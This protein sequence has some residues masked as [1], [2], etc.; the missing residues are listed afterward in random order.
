MVDA[1]KA[2]VRF[3]YNKRFLVIVRWTTRIG[4]CAATMIHNP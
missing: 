1:M 2:G 3:G 4:R